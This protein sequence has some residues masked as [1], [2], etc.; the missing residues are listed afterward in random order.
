MHMRNRTPLTDKEKQMARRL[1]AIWS[2]KKAELGY[3][4]LS[5]ASDMGFASQSTVSQYLNGGI[6]LNTDAK[7]KFARFLGIAVTDFDPDFAENSGLV[8]K[9]QIIDEAARVMSDMTP[10]QIDIVIAYAEG[11]RRASQP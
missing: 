5:A 3:S 11:L 8:S 2:A 9:S 6:A 4:Q 1:K 7:L 10:E